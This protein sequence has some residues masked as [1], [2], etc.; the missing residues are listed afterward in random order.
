MNVNYLKRYIISS[1]VLV[2][3]LIIFVAA[4]AS[5]IFKVSPVIMWMVR[6]IVAWS[7]SYLLLFGWKYFRT[8]EK[9]TTFLKRCFSAKVSLLPLLSS[10]G[11]TFGLSILSLFLYSLMT[12][13]NN[14]LLHQSRNRIIATKY[15]LIIHIRSDRRRIGVAWLYER[16]I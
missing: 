10:F 11:L 7:P 3:A 14:V 16:R 13:K 1:Y 15:F 6:N 8:D 2:W 9:R 5:L 12:Q 4:P